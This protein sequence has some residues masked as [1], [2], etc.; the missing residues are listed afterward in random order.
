[1][2]SASFD[3]GR[4]PGWAP[5]ILRYFIILFSIIICFSFSLIFRALFWLPER[6]FFDE[7]QSDQNYKKNGLQIRVLRHKKSPWTEKYQKMDSGFGLQAP[8]TPQTEIFNNVR[9]TAPL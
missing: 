3:P 2:T 5:D 8:K 1:M 4:D 9:E 6:T 7:P